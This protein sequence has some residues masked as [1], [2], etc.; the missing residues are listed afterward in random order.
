[1]LNYSILAMLGFHQI[2]LNRKKEQYFAN[3]S[4]VELMMA[5]LTLQSNPVMYLHMIGQMDPVAAGAVLAITK[6]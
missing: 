5:R 1:M 6:S 2:F 3:V 4:A